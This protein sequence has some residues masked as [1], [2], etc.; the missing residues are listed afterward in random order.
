MAANLRSA[1]LTG[2]NLRNA[3][4]RG[5]DL[6]GA[7]LSGADLRFA[8]FRDA[9]LS[10]ANLSG[11]Y[12]A[13]ADLTGADLTGADLT[14][15]DLTGAI[16]CNTTLDGTVLTG[17]NL[18]G[19][20][21]WKSK[22]YPVS[23]VS[24]SQYQGA[25]DDI[26]SVANLLSEIQKL[27][28][29]HIDYAEEIFFYFR[30]EPKC[31]WELRPS[32]TRE[33]FVID[34]SDMLLDL[35]SRRPEEFS[36]I[37]SALGQWVLAQHHELK[38]RFLDVSKNPLVA[39]FNACGSYVDAKED[40]RLYVFAA[41]RS[42]V[43]RFNSDVVSVVSNF[44]KL[45]HD[46]QNIILTKKGNWQDD[47]FTTPYFYLGMMRHLYQLIREEKPYF[48]ERIDP[49]DF[50]RV[51]VVE[52]QQSSERVR[53]QSG[54]FLAS[55]FHERFERDEISEW[56]TRIPVYAY[57]SLTVPS[58]SKSHIIEELRLLNV[59][60]ETLFPGLDSSASAIT[61]LYRQR[62]QPSGG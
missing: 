62:R 23:S 38:T 42:M 10:F 30:G 35:I 28:G 16:L 9:D 50:Y 61:E 36:G 24:P 45:S 44:A 60:H 46:E 1:D 29:H 27:Q 5:T 40:G 20:E 18:A 15:A 33:G 25:L 19:T 8:K 31:G 3:D 7:N 22:F 53:S 43:K 14:G 13:S 59:T 41:P 52:P 57:Y 34:E 51:F 4:L 37:S 21:F 11:T 12:L 56:N 6:N 55:A 39:L 48:E 49:R 58:N 47:T 32:V 17:T 26:N 2:A 54:A